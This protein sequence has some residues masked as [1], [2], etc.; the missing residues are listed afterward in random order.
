LGRVLDTIDEVGGIALVTADHGNS[1]EMYEYNKKTG[2]IKVDK[3]T[4]FKKVK[5]SHTLNP[6]PF[7]IYDPL[8]KGEYELNTGLLNP[9]LGNI[10]A[11]VF[12]LLG[13]YPPGGYDGS[14]IRML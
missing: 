7:I 6:V 2:K 11:T 9:G 13:Y 14:L 12:N 3:K 4:G 5:T 10:A 1:D 8:F